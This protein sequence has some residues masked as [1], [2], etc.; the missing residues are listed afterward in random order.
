MGFRE[1]R[2]VFAWRFITLPDGGPCVAELVQGDG[3]DNPEGPTNKD[4]PV[5]LI[6]KWI[7]PPTNH[8]SNPK[9]IRVR[10]KRGLRLIGARSRF[11][12]WNQ[13]AEFFPDPESFWIS[14]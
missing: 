5:L 3:E 8:Y 11:A 2:P 14:L 6:N 13:S 10:G 4:D 7:G 9:S 12:H 1:S